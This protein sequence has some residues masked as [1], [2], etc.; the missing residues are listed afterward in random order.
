MN[1]SQ[2]RRRYVFWRGSFPVLAGFTFLMLALCLADRIAPRDQTPV[3][4]AARVAL[5]AQSQTIF[6]IKQAA[7]SAARISY[8]CTKRCARHA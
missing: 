6:P 7:C 3:K 1:A 4:D 8:V 2:R 5:V